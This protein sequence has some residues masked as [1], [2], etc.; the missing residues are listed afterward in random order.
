MAF[1]IAKWWG[2]MPHVLWRYPFRYYKELRDH[3]IEANTPRDKD[4]ADDE[5]DWEDESLTGGPT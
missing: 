5:F 2:V 1:V 4:Q 3:Y